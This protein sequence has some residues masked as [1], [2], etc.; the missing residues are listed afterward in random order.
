MLELTDTARSKLMHSLAATKMP[1]HTG[2]CYR[3][4]PRDDKYLTLRLAK[5]A[6][7]DSI[8]RHDGHAILAVPKVLRS[9]FKDKTLDIDNTGKLKLS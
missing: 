3:I 2:K 7:D 4:I 8:V 1:D 5:P 6:A 9:F